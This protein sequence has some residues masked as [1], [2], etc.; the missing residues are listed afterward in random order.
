MRR[1]AW[2][3]APTAVDRAGASG[4]ARRDRWRGG[5]LGGGRGRNGRGCTV[6]TSGAGGGGCRGRGGDAGRA[7]S[8]DPAERGKA[9]GP[10]AR[11]GGRGRWQGVST[12][13]FTPPRPIA[14]LIGPPQ[15]RPPRARRG[16]VRRPSA[17]ARKRREGWPRPPPPPRAVPGPRRAWQHAGRSPQHGHTRTR[18]AVTGTGRCGAIAGR[19]ATRGAPRDAGGAPPAA[20]HRGAHA[21]QPLPQ[22]LGRPREHDAAALHV[23]RRVG[24][25]KLLKPGVQGDRR[26]GGWGG[27]ERGGGERGGERWERGW[28]AS[29]HERWGA[30][31]RS[32]PAGPPAARRP[33]LCVTHTAVTPRPRAPAR[34]T[35]LTARSTPNWSSTSR[36]V[37]SSSSSSTRGS[38]ASAPAPCSGCGGPGARR[39]RGRERAWCAWRGAMRQRCCCACPREPRAPA[40]TTT[41]PRG[42]RA[43]R[44]SR[45]AAAGHPTACASRGA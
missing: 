1:R 25:L 16:A 29:A 18:T 43:H 26:E 17:A 34:V 40:T 37:V 21:L 8:T 45:R 7:A 39:A 22:L 30:G 23:G 32:R 20:S 13:D 12:G 9:G 10:A 2:P 24:V 5:V 27:G 44:R 15:A 3:P 4:V 38:S 11:L 28:G 6:R 35:S 41:T 19:G 42:A 33:H 31:S 36:K 14:P